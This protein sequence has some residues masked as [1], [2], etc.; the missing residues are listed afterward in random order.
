MK[1]KIYTFIVALSLLAVNHVLATEHIITI[2]SGTLSF[3]PSTLV[4]NTGDTVTWQG[5]LSS[6]PLQSSSVPG[7]ATS[8]S[9]ASGN[10]FSYKV[11]V[12]G[13]YSYRCDLHHGSGMTGSFLALSDPVSVSD[14]RIS[15]W[16]PL[17]Q[18]SKNNILIRL[19]AENS[20][21]SLSVHINNILGQQV[22]SENVSV[23]QDV[24]SLS[25]EGLGKNIYVITIADSRQTLLTR[26][27]VVQ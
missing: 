11:T 10:S 7:N 22:W 21:P 1:T 4:V 23:Q 5:N 26:K 2:N 25:T 13:N 27:F 6:H 9:A 14:K 20:L 8:F 15:A 17:I 16:V 12:P 19:P 24:I 3:S 18:F